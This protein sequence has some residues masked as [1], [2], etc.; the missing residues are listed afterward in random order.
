MQHLFTF[1]RL[2]DVRLVVHIRAV[3]EHTLVVVG[4]VGGVEIGV[5]FAAAIATTRAER[6]QWLLNLMKENSGGRIAAASRITR[7]LFTNDL[8]LIFPL[9][10]NDR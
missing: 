5:Q 7:V 6:P 2:V 9:H 4:G 10:P 3:D 1:Q 8:I